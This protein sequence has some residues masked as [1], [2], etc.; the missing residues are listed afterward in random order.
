MVEPAIE[1]PF[2]SF[3]SI[4]DS[5]CESFTFQ[6]DITAKPNWLQF[7]ISSEGLITI[8]ANEDGYYITSGTGQSSDKKIIKVLTGAVIATNIKNN[9]TV[10]VIKYPIK[11]DGKLDVDYRD[12]NMPDWLDFDI[13]YEIDSYI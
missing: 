4:L 13:D 11:S 12:Q 2:V 9:S 3:N 10:T 1:T 6:G 7:S 8:S 5:N